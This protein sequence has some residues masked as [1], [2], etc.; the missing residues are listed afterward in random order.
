MRGLDHREVQL[1]GNCLRAAADGP[2]FEDWEFATLFGLERAEVKRIA[3]EWPKV[4][5]DDAIV[6]RAVQ[7]SLNNLLGYPHGM[8]AELEATVPGSPAAI[9]EVLVKWRDAG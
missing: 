2:F 4:D 7:N 1:I 8:D 5:A 9:E 3:E 6:A